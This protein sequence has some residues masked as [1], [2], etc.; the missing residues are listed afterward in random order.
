MGNIPSA[1]NSGRNSPQHVGNEGQESYPPIRRSN[2]LVAGLRKSSQKTFRRRFDSANGQ[3]NV[4]SGDTSY[5][6][7]TEEEISD[8]TKPNVSKHTSVISSFSR[9]VKS[10][11]H[12]GQAHSHG[13]RSKTPDGNGTRHQV[14]NGHPTRPKSGFGSHSFI[15][16]NTND[17][18]L[19]S[20]Q[21]SGSNS[22]TNSK[23]TSPCNAKK[24]G[25]QSS[26]ST[27]SFASMRS[28]HSF[29]NLHIPHFRFSGFSGH[30]ENSKSWQVLQSLATEP[31]FKYDMTQFEFIK[32][33]GSGA[34]GRVLL[35]RHLLTNMKVVL[36]QIEKKHVIKTRQQHHLRDERDALKD[37]SEHD[38]PFVVHTVGCFQDKKNIYF[39]MEYVPGGE[40]FAHLRAS[41]NHHFS[42]KRTRFYICETIL[43]LQHM[44]EK[45][46]IVY[47]DIKPENM[48]LDDTG[49]L[50]IVDFGFAK[51]LDVSERTFTFCGTP[52]Y[53]APEVVL[54]KGSG[55]QADYWALGVLT[56]ELLVGHAPFVTVDERTNKITYNEILAGRPKFS[57]GVS[58]KAKD[59]ILAL[60]N[61][62]PDKRLGA[63]N[64]MQDV[65]NHEWFKEVDWGA[66][67]RREVKPP[68]L[69]KC[70][71]GT[72]NIQPALDPG[73][74]QSEE[75]HMDEASREIFE[76]FDFAIGADGTVVTDSRH[77]TVKGAGKISGGVSSCNVNP[78]HVIEAIAEAQDEGEKAGS[79]ISNDGGIVLSAERGVVENAD[80]GAGTGSSTTEGHGRNLGRQL[81][82]T[83]VRNGV[84]THVGVPGSSPLSSLSSEFHSSHISTVQSS[85]TSKQARK[86]IVAGNASEGSQ[87]I[88]ASPKSTA[89]D[90]S[91]RTVFTTDSEIAT[92]AMPHTANDEYPASTPALHRVRDQMGSNSTSAASV[93]S[94]EEGGLVFDTDPKTDMVCSSALSPLSKNGANGRMGCPEDHNHCSVIL[95]A[96]AAGVA[97]TNGNAVNT[98]ESAHETAAACKGS[99][100]S[101]KNTDTCGLDNVSDT[102]TRAQFFIDDEDLDN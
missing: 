89:T 38:C 73:A 55:R 102:T 9:R 41:T 26:Q 17:Q 47:R 81:S 31:G 16:N 15:A 43:A 68:K 7:G 80:I 100:K 83:V 53:L 64:G 34:F 76:Q 45:E 19:D 60:L 87:A 35:C 59:F 88:V 24:N 69:N 40:L 39:V 101:V 1:S 85:A 3:E 36:K 52:D 79:S 5:N 37:L 8:D 13:S 62:D 82:H 72:V 58:Q 14:H 71:K 12:V 51:H 66:M 99:G 67:L 93:D 94:M 75:Y 44:H 54:G 97:R 74:R 2:S 22:N 27:N 77:S 90:T 91:E 57:K 56:Y 11:G 46:H 32:Q 92:S 33:I 96:D 95:E 4:T 10:Y 70:K 6:E 23:R 42:E 30:H 28:N 50:K 18:D 84:K 86:P 98:A 21:G 29:H 65:K 78:Q 25:L 20:N 63:K 61:P 48:L 49:H